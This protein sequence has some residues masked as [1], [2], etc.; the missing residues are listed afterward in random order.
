MKNVALEIRTSYGKGYLLKDGTRI[1]VNNDTG[2]PVKITQEQWK[3]LSKDV[4]SSYHG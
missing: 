2:K 1:Y 4:V 3:R